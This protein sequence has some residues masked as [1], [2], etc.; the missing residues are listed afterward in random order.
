MYNGR[1]IEYSVSGR[2]HSLREPWVYDGTARDVATGETGEKKHFETADW[3]IN[4]A[5]EELV[6]KLKE[7]KLIKD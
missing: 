3:A 7:R 5:I 1:T 6:K 2:F 4:G